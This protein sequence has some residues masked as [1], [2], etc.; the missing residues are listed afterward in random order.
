MSKHEE[1]IQK[2]RTLIEALPYIKHFRGKT[3]VIKY[4]GSIMIDEDLKTLFAEDIALLRYVGINPLIVHGGG[5]EISKWMHKLGKETVFIDGQR[6]TDEETMEITEMVLSGKINNEIVSL[7]NRHGGHAVG[8]S[9][10]SANLYTASKIRSKK[11]EDL[12]YVGQIQSVD[13]SLLTTLFDKGYIP[14]VS[15][16]GCDGNGISLNL[17]ADNVASAIAQH[18]QAEKLIYLTD[19]EGL[20]L[21]S[22]LQSEMDLEQ[23]KKAMG[24]HDVK[25]GMLPKLDCSIRA[26]EN[27]V[28]TVHIINGTLEHAVLLEVFTDGGVGTMITKDCFKKQSEE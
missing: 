26:I 14:V 23:A 15:S 6:F 19:V 4:G 3:L 24:S 20:M 9:G 28:E 25:G 12:G 21:D 10:K 8:L 13:A 17:N 11:D 5:K 27:G 22:I 16:I 2:A 18:L 7:L 1:K